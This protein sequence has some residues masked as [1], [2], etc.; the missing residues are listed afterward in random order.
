MGTTP[1]FAKFILT[2]SEVFR[3]GYPP[4]VLRII[5]PTAFVGIDG[6][7]RLPL[8]KIVTK[9]LSVDSLRT[10]VEVLDDII[11]QRLA[12]WE[13]RGTVVGLTAAQEVGC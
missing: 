9:P 13:Q 4:V 8:R 3:G 12:A 5:G 11:Y 7:H 10:K 2:N 6:P 1:D